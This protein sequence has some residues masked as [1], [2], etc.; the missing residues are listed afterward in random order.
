MGF[1]KQLKAGLRF[2]AGRSYFTRDTFQIGHALR[3]MRLFWVDKVLPQWPTLLAY[4]ALIL[5]AYGL[6]S[7]VFYNLSIQPSLYEGPVIFSQWLLHGSLVARVLLALVTLLLA[8]RVS[9]RTLVDSSWLRPLVLAMVGLL[10]LF[11]L[12]IPPNPYF[13]QFYT[14]DRLLLLALALLVVANI[15]RRQEGG[16][17][18]ADVG[19]K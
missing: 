3:W 18:L 7:L 6:R 19:E 17:R 12:L 13:G 14:I 4:A 8:V 5:L 10:L 15:A 2:R 9:W 16:N 11:A 1:A